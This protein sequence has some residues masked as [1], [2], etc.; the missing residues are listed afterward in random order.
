MELKTT[1]DEHIVFI[2]CGA[3]RH[4]LY[5]HTGLPG[6]GSGPRGPAALANFHNQVL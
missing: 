2:V 5:N 3:K 1:R 4:V 6:L